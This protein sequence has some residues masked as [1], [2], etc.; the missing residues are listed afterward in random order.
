M[1]QLKINKSKLESIVREELASRIKEL[2]LQN[3][4][5]KGEEEPK[6][7]DGE[8]APEKTGADKENDDGDPEVAGPDM[9]P[10]RGAEK[11]PEKP[12]GDQEPPE[13]SPVPKDDDDDGAPE[14]VPTGDDPSDDELTRD[15]TD[16]DSEN[17]EPG[18]DVSDEV[19]GKTIQSI[20]YEPESK[21]M[22]G[23][24]ELVLQFEEIPHPLRVIIGKSGLVKFFFR[25]SVHNEL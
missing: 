16:P 20:T 22:A 10:K 7:K 4:E 25:G 13:D 24:Q 3:E 1:G 14:E 23:A 19:T 5:E 12:S 2:L 18:G 9:A 15:V 17:E 21:M 6:K 8:E 11:G